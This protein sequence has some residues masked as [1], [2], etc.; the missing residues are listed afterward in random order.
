MANVESKRRYGYWWWVNPWNSGDYVARGWGGQAIVV[1]PEQKVV[2]V[3]TA[4][5]HGM[6]QWISRDIFLYA[7]QENKPLPAAPNALSRLKAAIMALETPASTPV[8][9]LPEI[10]KKVSGKTYQLSPNDGQVTDIRFEF[11]DG[12]D[13]AR[14]I[15]GFN[16]SGS[17]STSRYDFEIGLD[18]LYRIS[19]TG[20]VGPKPSGNQTAMR[21]RWTGAD[22]LE[23]EDQDLG[24][25]L[26]AH[27]IVRFNGD[28]LKME[29][30][31]R[32]TGREVSYT[33]QMVKEPP[34]AR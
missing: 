21:G 18:G 16:I 34:A 23:I 22:T 15:I 17:T 1:Q 11:E 5:D 14:L 24:G 20:D 6:P 30:Q 2:L 13:S 12:K 4:A 27:R 9:K 29:V 10:A 33:G 8:Q 19:D 25:V 26:V 28:T 7:V 32:P 3:V 31:L